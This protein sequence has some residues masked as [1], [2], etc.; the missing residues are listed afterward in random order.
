MLYVLCYVLRAVLCYTRCIMIYALAELCYTYCAM[1][2][3]LCY[4]I[5]A[6]LCYT[7]CVM[8]YVPCYIIRGAYNITR[9]NNI[10]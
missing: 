5:R 6:V 7:Y 8:L 2:Y 4:V 10:T 1:L 9:T 3:A